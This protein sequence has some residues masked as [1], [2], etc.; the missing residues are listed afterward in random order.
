MAGSASDYLENRIIDHAF[1][2]KT[3]YTKPVVY[4]ALYTVAPGEA[5]GGTE[6][7]GNAYARVTTAGADWNAASGGVAT[8]A[9]AFTWPTPTGA[10]WGTIVA[11]GGMDAL[12]G[13]NLLW[14]DSSITPQVGAAGVAVSIPAGQLSVTHT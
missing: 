5:G 4:L 6:V 9:N 12:T 2:G 13:G 14:S 10:G 8:N 1:T 7:T 11:V 3:A